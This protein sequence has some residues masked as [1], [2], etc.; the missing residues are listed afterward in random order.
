LGTIDAATKSAAGGVGASALKTITYNLGSAATVTAIGA[1]DASDENGSGTNAGSGVAQLDAINF[2]LGA[3]AVGSVTVG[4]ISA[5]SVTA[6]NFTVAAQTNAHAT[7]A[8]LTLDESLGAATIV[9]GANE[10]FTLTVDGIDDAATDLYNLAIGTI[11]GSGAGNVVIAGLT[12]VK[13]IA[14]INLSAVSGTSE[15]AA[16][17][18]SGTSGVSIT[19]GTGGTTSTGVSGSNNADVI[20]GGAKAD[21]ISGGAGADDI[22][23]GLGADV[24]TGGAGADT[25]NLTETT[26]SVD[27]IFYAESGAANVDQVTGFKAGTDIVQ[28]S[29]GNIDGAATYN[30]ATAGGTD[31]SAAASPTAATVVV[32]TSG[33]VADAANLLFFSNTAATSF[34]TAIGTA[35]ITDTTGTDITNST[36]IAAIYYD[37]ANG[38]AVFG[39]VYDSNASE[40]ITTA[41]T[42]VEITRVGMLSTD[43]TSSNVAASFAF[44]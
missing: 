21:T 12:T 27:K 34:A 2:T 10:T 28:Y 35:S 22:T 11:A 9:A 20:V 15:V 5:R 17:T 41:D 4:A 3:D 16:S 25:I 43:F 33:A 37:S 31:I 42:F 7:G 44:V 26:S 24:I 29:I 19:I 18:L 14:D 6:A 13:S 36:S 40:T 38:Q 39:Y 30:F 32:N 23:G 1:I 8:T